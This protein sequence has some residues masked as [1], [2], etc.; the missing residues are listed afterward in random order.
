MNTC[1]SESMKITT[2][3]TLKESLGEVKWAI[4]LWET[5]P[6]KLTSNGKAVQGEYYH[7]RTLGTSHGLCSVLGIFSGLIGEG[8][9]QY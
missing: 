2:F 7:G 3:K 8:S 5:V 6:E 1:W 4:G 9:F